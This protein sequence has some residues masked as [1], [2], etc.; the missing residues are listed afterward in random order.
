MIESGV[1]VVMMDEGCGFCKALTLVL[2]G[3]LDWRGI[4]HSL[5]FACSADCWLR[6]TCRLRLAKFS[7]W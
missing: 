4:A 5:D 1:V 3:S 2:A 6:V 7:T